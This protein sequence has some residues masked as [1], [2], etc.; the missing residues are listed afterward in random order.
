MQKF[1]CK[2]YPCLLSG[3]ATQHGKRGTAAIG[4]ISLLEKICEEK[5]I[6][7]HETVTCTKNSILNLKKSCD[8]QSPS[9]KLMSHRLHQDIWPLMGASRH[10]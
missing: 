6:P 2:H 10:A 7:S 5:R 1:Y 3:S 8:D 9:Y 4:R